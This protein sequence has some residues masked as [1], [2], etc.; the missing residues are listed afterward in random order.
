[1]DIVLA[2][3]EVPVTNCLAHSNTFDNVSIPVLVIDAGAVSPARVEEHAIPG[4]TK[5]W[6]SF[7]QLQE[8]V[9]E[10]VGMSDLLG[11]ATLRSLLSTGLEG[12][13]R[14]SK[15]V[16][17][18]PGIVVTVEDEDGNTDVRI[19]RRSKYA[20]PSVCWVGVLTAVEIHSS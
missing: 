5:H 17:H 4:V 8:S 14:S 10:G 16:A 1:V 2:S 7:Q 3:L 9:M 12:V 20:L 15:D 11:G 13:N 18:L 19:D 6:T